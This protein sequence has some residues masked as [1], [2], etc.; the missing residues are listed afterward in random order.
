MRKVIFGMMM[1]GIG[2]TAHATEPAASAMNDSVTASELFVR[3]PTVTLDILTKSMRKDMLDYLKIDSIYNVMNTMEGFSHINPPVTPDYFQV[4]ITPVTR[5]TMRLLPYKES[6]IVLTLYTVGDS[7]QAE[8]SEI[9]FYDL[10]L[11]E[12]KRDKYIKTLS[13]D[14]FLDLKGVDGKLQKELKGLVPFPTVKYTIGPDDE[15]L[16]AELTVGE[17]LSKESLE[18]I[19]PYIHRER[20]MVWNGKKFE[21]KR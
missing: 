20:E 19:A 2:L 4:Q 13:T 8:D 17:F 6:K 21:L 14:D 1:M 11:N 3:M 12:L 15:T 9:R 16:K 10:N 7:V 5:Y 18:K